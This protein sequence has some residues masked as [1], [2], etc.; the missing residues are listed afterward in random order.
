M[1]SKIRKKSHYSFYQKR[2]VTPKYAN[3]VLR[4]SQRSPP[5]TYRA[6]RGNTP[7]HTHTPILPPSVSPCCGVQK[8][9]KCQTKIH[10]LGVSTCL[11]SYVIVAI[12]F[13]CHSFCHLFVV[14]LS[15]SRMTHERVFGCRPNMVGMGR[16]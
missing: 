14:V 16:V 1:E 11:R 7:P 5:R 8:Y 6:G 4:R 12:K 2:S 13:V 10:S 3:N 9:S 15:V